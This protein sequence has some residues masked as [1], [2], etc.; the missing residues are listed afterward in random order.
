M[1]D[2]ETL[3]DR[4]K[5]TNIDEHTLLATD[6]LNHFNEIVML[7]EIVPD[8]PEFIAEAKDWRPKSY[9]GHFRDSSFSEKDLAIAAYE[10]VQAKYRQ[11][12]EAT[13]GRMNRLVAV[14][15]ERI[16]AALC[17]DDG[18]ELQTVVTNA[19]DALRR[20]IDDASAVIHGGQPT[21]EQTEI[22]R[23]LRA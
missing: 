21:M 15:I 5:G 4:I 13:I 6:Y 7:L 3:R 23:L 8:M 22:D 16:E 17:S 2:F 19:T 18:A 12:F 10:H 20:L 11:P 1:D 14:S 9:Q